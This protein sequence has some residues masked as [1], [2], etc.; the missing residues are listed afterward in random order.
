MP[1]EDAAPEPARAG[2]EALAAS[3]LQSY[4]PGQTS[5]SRVLYLRHFLLCVVLLVSAHRDTHRSTLWRAGSLLSHVCT[6]C[7]LLPA[8][9]GALPLC[10]HQWLSWALSVNQPVSIPPVCPIV[11][12]GE[13]SFLFAFKATPFLCLICE[14]LWL[15]PAP[16]WCLF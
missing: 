8:S 6:V 16:V 3:S 1:E 10:P 4:L 9:S 11:L 15:L 5:D 13:V 12:L 2:S 7:M 14:F